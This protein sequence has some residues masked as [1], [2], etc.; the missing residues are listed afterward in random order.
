MLPIG[1]VGIMLISLKQSC[2]LNH[3]TLYKFWHPCVCPV[4]ML[5]EQFTC[6]THDQ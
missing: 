6:W 4:D 2:L 3:M 1:C 5:I